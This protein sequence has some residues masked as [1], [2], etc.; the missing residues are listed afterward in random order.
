MNKEKETAINGPMTR[1]QVQ[2]DPKVHAKIMHWVNK[3]TGECSGLGKVQVEGGSL[4]VIDACLVKQEN[5]GASTEMDGGAVAKAM[6]EMRETPGHLNFWWHSHVN[7]DVFWSGTDID[8][9]RDIGKNGFLVSS[10]FNKRQ[11]IKS[12][13]YVNAG[14]LFPE[15]F[16]DDLPTFFTCVTTQEER[17]VWDKEFDEKCK[18]ARWTY[19]GN[20]R[21]Y[22]RSYHY[23][24]SPYKGRQWD[25]TKGDWTNGADDAP[26]YREGNRDASSEP[27]DF[28]QEMEA[29][30]QEIAQA[31]KSSLE[32]NIEQLLIDME[33]ESDGAEARSMLHD[34]IRLVNNMSDIS[35]DEK[36][37]RKQEMIMRFNVSRKV[38]NESSRSGAV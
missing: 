16:F 18:D 37:D 23:D 31:K 21:G 11:E 22:L 12:A 2:I 26:S 28:E 38:W 4:R 27:N 8:T 15:L 30:N 29:K 24:D 1:F 32:R 35:A 14:E 6:Y 25:W 3:A 19:N 10:V 36:L 13:L 5:A 33:G 17:E 20:D 7:M 9:I 34:A